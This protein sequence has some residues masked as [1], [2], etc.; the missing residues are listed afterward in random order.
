MRSVQRGRAAST[1]LKESSFREPM[2]RFY[3]WR[4]VA[5]SC[6]VHLPPVRVANWTVR[7]QHDYST[8]MSQKTS[9]TSAPVNMA[10]VRHILRGQQDEKSAVAAAA[11]SRRAV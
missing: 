10:E 9:F 3:A 2:T 6:E 8:G 1:G 5:G 11:L 7:R 4:E